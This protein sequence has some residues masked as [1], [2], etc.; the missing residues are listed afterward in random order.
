[1]RASTVLFLGL[2]GTFAFVGHARSRI[3][4]PL[5]LTHGAISEHGERT[6]RTRS[7]E[8]EH[9]RLEKRGR[10]LDRALKAVDRSVETL[11]ALAGRS[12][13]DAVRAELAAVESGRARLS[14]LRQQIE[15]QKAS[16]VARLHLARAGVEEV[17]VQAPVERAAIEPG[18]AT[19]SPL[20]ALER[21]GSGPDVRADSADACRHSLNRPS[22]RSSNKTSPVTSRAQ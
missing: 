2:V 14:D 10:E 13:V 1:M 15:A 16:T 6:S 20:D 8:H 19:L 17:D 9:D 12:D 18:S 5:A 3:G 4:C 11:R 21:L 22:S 7:L